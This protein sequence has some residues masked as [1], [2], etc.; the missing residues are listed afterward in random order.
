ML[1]AN[2][3]TVSIRHTNMDRKR[4]TVNIKLALRIPGRRNDH[5]ITGKRTFSFFSI[6]ASIMVMV[7]SRHLVAYVDG[8]PDHPRRRAIRS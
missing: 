7:R 5:M 8:V 6:A 2:L 4:L 1:T 3:A